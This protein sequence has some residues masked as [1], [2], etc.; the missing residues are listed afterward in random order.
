M[1]SQRAILG[2]GLAVLM[3]IGAT[4]VFFDIKS[5][6]DAG[7]VNHTLEVLKQL[8]DAQLLVRRA[9]SAA[10]G[11]ALTN[12]PYFA[13]EYREALDQI[14]PA[15]SELIEATN[16]NPTQWPLLASAKQI[17]ARQLAVTGD[18]VRLRETGDAAGLAA[19]T[20]KAEGRG[21][22][23][24][25]TENFDRLAAEEQR[26][27]AIRSAQ[28]QQTGRFL[29]AADLSGG[30][31]ILLLAAILMRRS[32]LFSRKLEGS[33]RYKEVENQALEIAVAERTGHLVTAQ[34]ELRRS[35]SVLKGTFISIAEAILVV[36]ADGAILLANLAA[37][38]LLGYC[39]G[40]TVDQL[41]TKN[42]SYQ[43]DGATILATHDTPAARAMRGEQFDQEEVVIRQ[44]DRRDPIHI[45]VSSR[46]L[47]D[48]AGEFTGAALVYHDVTRT[49]EAE[50]KLHQ[51]QKLDA[52]GK[53][54][55]GVAHD[56]NNMLTVIT[57]TTETLVAEL[58][59][60]AD[61]QAVA[62]LIN[63]AADRCTELIKHLLAFAR[64][65][66]LQPR[67]V[68]I[69]A[70]IQD[71]GKL[72][73]PTLGEQIEIESS[74]ENRMS[75]V[76]IDPSQLANALLNL[77]L[78]ARDAMPNGGKLI[79]ETAN[80]VLDEAYALVNADVRPG[81]YAMI[82][83]S[84]TGTGMSPE[85]RDK[86]FEPFFTTKETG[87]GT[88]LGLSMVYGFVKQ[89]GGHI[90]IY[91][92]EG[93]G[94]TVRL[95]LP[96][97]TGRV[98]VAIAMVEPAQGAGETIL[99]VEDDELVRGFV[100]AQLHSL[101][102]RTFAAADSR[103]A[104][105][106][107]ERGQPFE[108]LFTDIVMPGGMTGRELADEVTRRRPG[109]RVLYTSGYTENAIVHHG[110]LD[111]GVMLLSKPYRKSELSSMVRRALGEA[112]APNLESGPSPLADTS[113]AARKRQQDATS[114]APSSSC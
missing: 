42:V 1:R 82:A 35:T 101:G 13:T 2:A 44:P 25:I 75:M 33:L 55:G 102:Y 85:V 81:A 87:K 3:L 64:K 41:R 69:N 79:L 20:A 110:R 40:M 52:I 93:H 71:M 78:N 10:R 28:S 77:A 50:R 15:F 86:V 54:T 74:L 96:I 66:P 29:V 12:D 46:S 70:T 94:T 73:S 56:F 92:E 112:A 21:A 48:T 14:E 80:V 83:V 45:M 99:V 18:L 39:R 100:I 61:L 59:D 58:G 19:L 63:Q 4:S 22:M 17:V 109:T 89:S 98:D 62:A 114:Q 36:D 68:D 53:L 111:P 6:A 8:S 31:L 57:G 107:L 95:Y 91:S 60:R 30:A 11:F 32:R 97:A 108:V 47:H 26:L 106:Y 105:A 9:E 27:L 67:N 43:A 88:G 65:Q 113:I 7:W 37:E 34:E 103:A 104:L 38:R 72:L 84:D 24:S 49:R 5:R 51:S 90:K 16:D 76:C 23:D